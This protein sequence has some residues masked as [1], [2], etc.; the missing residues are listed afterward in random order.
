MWLGKKQILASF[1]WWLL[2]IAIPQFL[3]NLCFYSSKSRGINQSIWVSSCLGRVG[4]KRNHGE[5]EN[6]ILYLIINLWKYQI[7]SWN[8]KAVGFF[9]L[10][11]CGK[12][13]YPS[14]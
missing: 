1:M 5:K 11:Q 10:P 6:E 7:Y 13:V 9:K 12:D 14:T 4:G 8:Y 2:W 3:W